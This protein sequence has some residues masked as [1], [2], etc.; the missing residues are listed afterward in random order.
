VFVSDTISPETRTL[1]VRTEVENAD[2]ALKP[3]MLATLRII[4]AV[5]QQLA[6]PEAA[7]VRDNAIEC[8]FLDPLRTLTDGNENDNSIQNRFIEAIEQVRNTTGA[9]IGLIHHASKMDASGARGASAFRDGVRWVVSI[10][11]DGDNAV[12]T[13]RKSNYTRAGEDTAITMER[14][15]TSYGMYLRHVPTAARAAKLSA[16]EQLALAVLNGRE[17]MLVDEFRREF[18][19]RH[20]GTEDAKKQA[21]QRLRRASSVLTVGDKW[22]SVTI[23]ESPRDYDANTNAADDNVPRNVPHQTPDGAGFAHKGTRGTTGGHGENVPLPTRGTRGTF[24]I[25]QCP[26]VPLGATEEN[27]TGLVLIDDMKKRIPKRT[28]KIS[29]IK[30]TLSAHGYPTTTAGAIQAA[31]AGVITEAEGDLF[32]EATGRYSRQA[33]EATV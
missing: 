24:A 8:C 12:A 29:D 13:I 33:S 32:V 3:Q 22:L 1:M 5:R 14:I 30:R 20:K 9:A 16:N 17:K 21:I 19:A 11:S 4:G 10:E 7:V 18:Y 23:S 2:R 28:A 26:P 6:V 31:A 15:P 27:L 25:K